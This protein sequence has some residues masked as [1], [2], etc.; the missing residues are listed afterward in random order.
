MSDNWTTA[1]VAAVSVVVVVDAAVDAVD[2]V[3]P[4]G[5]GRVDPPLEAVSTCPDLH[6]LQPT[7]N[8]EPHC[9]PF[10]PCDPCKETPHVPGHRPV[11]FAASVHC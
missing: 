2:G 7:L 10:A 5:V 9:H 8:E 4:F 3:G 1:V 6:K 11:A